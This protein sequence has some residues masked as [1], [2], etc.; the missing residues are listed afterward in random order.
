MTEVR[1][2]TDSDRLAFLAKCE[3]ID[4]SGY[5]GGWSFHVMVFPVD[6]GL[7][8][9]VTISTRAHSTRLPESLRESVDSAMAV[10]SG[11]VEEK[12]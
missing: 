8:C 12:A 11:V 7:V 1:E 6:K 10:L 5:E 3:R 4:R 9:D 2:N